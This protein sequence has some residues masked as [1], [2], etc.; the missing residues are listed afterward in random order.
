[1]KDFNTIDPVA[2]P[3]NIVA[4][5]PVVTEILQGCRDFDSESVSIS[6]S[7]SNHEPVLT[8][9]LLQF[10]RYLPELYP[11][12]TDMLAREMAPDLWQAV[13]SFYVKTG[14]VKGMMKET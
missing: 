10:E 9:Q 14:V 3:R 5:T 2:Q 7:S 12:V 1:M 8:G 13:R 11:L 6:V 4:W